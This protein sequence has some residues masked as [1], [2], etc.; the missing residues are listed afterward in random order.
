MSANAQVNVLGDGQPSVE[1]VKEVE[2]AGINGHVRRRPGRAQV[3][4]HLEVRELWN[5][6]FLR[7]VDE[8]I[9]RADDKGVTV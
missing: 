1:P 6:G 8:G 9:E 4:P 7:V 5:V 3:V 2:E